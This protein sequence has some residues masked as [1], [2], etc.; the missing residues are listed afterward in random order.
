[1]EE[2]CTLT[3][4]REWP[5]LQIP[6]TETECGVKHLKMPHRKKWEGASRHPKRAEVRGS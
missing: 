6:I 4:Q 3:R 5:S 1:M 2:A